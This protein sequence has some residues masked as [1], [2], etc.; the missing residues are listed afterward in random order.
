MPAGGGVLA[1]EGCFLFHVEDEQAW[2]QALL[3]GLAAAAV[4]GAI[5]LLMRA[6]RRRGRARLGSVLLAVGLLV[7]PVSMVPLT[8]VV[9]IRD[10]P[11][12][13][14]PSG[15]RV[16]AGTFADCDKPIYAAW[17]LGHDMPT[18]A[19]RIAQ[20]ACRDAAADARRTSGLLLLV[21]VGLVVAGAVVGR[22]ARSTT[23]GP[24]ADAEP[25]VAT[26]P[27]AASPPA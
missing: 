6:W 12:V 13:T 2:T 9:V 23:D 3:V 17:N 8:T 15:A 7:V 4:V 14:T 1:C 21:A 27:P 26:G 18:E 20:Q 16:R 10:L 19:G 5:V 22:A 24:A 25:P 11:F